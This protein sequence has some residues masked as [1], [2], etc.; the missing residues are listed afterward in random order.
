MTYVIVLI[1]KYNE[2][3]SPGGTEEV[4]NATFRADNEC[5]GLE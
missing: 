4:E 3:W 1:L 2:T 5:T